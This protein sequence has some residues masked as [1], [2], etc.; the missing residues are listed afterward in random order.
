VVV[1]PVQAFHE[2][3]LEPNEPLRLAL[4]PYMLPLAQ[5]MF[6]FAQFMVALTLFK[7]VLAKFPGPCA[8]RVTTI[9]QFPL[10]GF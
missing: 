6:P 1:S 3:L 5:F 9:A 7:I 8:Q 4:V 2:Q 10:F